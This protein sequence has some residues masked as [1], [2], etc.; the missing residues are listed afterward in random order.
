MK[1]SLP[2]FRVVSRCALVAAALAGCSD[3][4]GF[5][6][7]GGGLDALPGFDAGEGRDSGVG[8]GGVDGGPS[9]AG[10]VDSGLDGGPRDAGLDSGLA[11]GG[12]DA[13]MPDGGTDSGV[14]AAPS[15]TCP[16]AAIH[17]GHTIV[18]DGEADLDAYPATQR[19]TPG[20]PLGS[21]DE[22]AITWDRDYLYVTLVSG[23]FADGFKPVHIYLEAAE[24]LG[25][26]MPSDGKEY[27]GLVARLPF[28]ATH[29]VALR[30]TSVGGDGVAYNG[31]YVPAGDPPWTTQTVAFREGVDV[32]TA[33]DAS[34]MSVRVSWA[35]LGCPSALRL[36]AH[37]VN[38]V[39]A[40]E[41]KDFLPFAATPWAA[42][43]GAY[44]E[45]DL[46]VE[47]DVS[48]WVERTP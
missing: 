1:R 41:W 9:D 39:L 32:F 25:A 35:D 4:G 2:C 18:L 47:P 29:L 28:S 16:G 45:L 11:D 38:A 17:P 27:S 8:D 46:R 43:G 14:D 48:G 23:A 21:A 3:G 20:G 42:P 6:D 33:S 24:T 13:V 34:A 37:V 12:S 44:F 19:L 40:N 22:Y 5:P 7:A 36:T 31:L 15:A 26:A 30:R 10:P